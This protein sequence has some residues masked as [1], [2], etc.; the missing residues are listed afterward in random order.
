[1]ADTAS[2]KQTTVYVSVWSAV[3]SWSSRSQV[4]ATKLILEGREYMTSL[5]HVVPVRTIKPHVQQVDID[6]TV[7][8]H[9]CM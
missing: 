7:I 3:G 8:S 1:M 2:L 9:P 5:K 6:R 4:T